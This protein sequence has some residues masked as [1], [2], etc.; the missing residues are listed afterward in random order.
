MPSSESEVWA[1]HPHPD[2]WLLMLILIVGYMAAL[3]FWGPREAPDPSRPAS[4]RQRTWYGLG[5]AALWVGADWPL[6][7]MS[8]DYLL[9]AHMVQHMLFTFIAPPLLL[10]G[11]PRWML[12]R[13]L[14]PRWL[15]ATVRAATKPLLALIVFNAVIAVTHWPALVDLALRVELVHFAVHTLLVTTALMM[16]WPV[17]GP[18]PEMP[19]LNDPVRMIYLFGQSILPTVPASFL[20]FA[21]GVVYKFYAD[22][23]RLWGTSVVGDQQVAG[24]IM[25]LGGGL[26]LWSI[27]VV[28]FFKW[29]AREEGGH[30][31]ELDW[32]DF[33]RELEAYK[34]RK[35]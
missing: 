1:W 24:L 17:I 30:T 15:A 33:E 29:S 22:V 19:R 23:P 13:L 20:T 4:I 18:L 35:T 14:K 8:E 9:S 27:I 3:R 11:M 25:K 6:H 10:M 16:W 26:L 34:L 5:V 31:E 12:R 7:E 2:V 21:E 32:E 28:L